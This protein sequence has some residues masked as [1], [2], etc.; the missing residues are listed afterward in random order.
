M[1]E[2]LAPSRMSQ[3]RKFIFLAALLVLPGCGS[4]PPPGEEK[5][6]EILSVDFPDSIK[7]IGGRYNLESTSLLLI[8]S[9]EPLPRPEDNTAKTARSRLATPAE[10]VTFPVSALLTLAAA[11]G[12]V[13]E[14]VPSFTQEQGRCHD[15]QVGDFR[16][17][18]REAQTEKGW[19]TAVEVF[20]NPDSQTVEN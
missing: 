5:V 9:K 20:K 16:F 3:A 8:A 10:G 19:L 11:N 13:R 2:R 12:V 14:D 17:S 7:V 15:G 4:E 6:E 1:P 18:F